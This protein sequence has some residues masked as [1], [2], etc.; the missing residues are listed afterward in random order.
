MKITFL[1]CD[2]KT[3][4]RF[5]DDLLYIGMSQHS[6]EQA[7]NGMLA[8]IKYNRSLGLSNTINFPIKGRLEKWDR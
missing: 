8:A 7:A 3:G 1:Q 5:E 4:E 2:L 6:A